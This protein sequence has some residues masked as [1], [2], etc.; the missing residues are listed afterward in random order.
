[1]GVFMNDQRQAGR[2]IARLPGGRKAK[3][4]SISG[5]A[6]RRMP[7]SLPAAGTRVGIFLVALL[8]IAAQAVI[9]VLF[10]ALSE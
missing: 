1:M 3:D 7:A 4:I 10:I 5:I 8:A 9:F 6:D 2:K